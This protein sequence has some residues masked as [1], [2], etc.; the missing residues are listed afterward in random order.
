MEDKIIILPK[1]ELKLKNGKLSYLVKTGKYTE[2]EVA[3]IIPIWL[4]KDMLEDLQGMF[5]MV[6]VMRRKKYR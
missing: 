3:F 1:S 6:Y 2:T 4:K 5:G